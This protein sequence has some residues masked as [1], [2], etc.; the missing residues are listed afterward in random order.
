MAKVEITLN[1]L[2]NLHS[3]VIYNPDEFKN[4]SSV[5]ID[6]R[7]VVKGSIF[8]AIEG[9]KFDGHDFVND[10]EANDASALIINEKKLSKFDSVD[11]TIITVPDTTE[12]YGELAS[13][14][15]KKLSA[16]VISISGSNGKTTTKDILAVILSEKFNVVKTIANNNNHIGVPLTIFLADQKCEILILEHGTNHFGEIAYTAKIAIPDYVLLTNIGDSHL[17]FLIDRKGVYKEKSA[18]FNQH[19]NLLFVNND[20]KILSRKSAGIKNKIS[21]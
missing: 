8:F 2:F 20:D 5:V 12:A 17:E 4:S 11:A 1:D 18:L 7:E 21:F 10:A 16:K 14:W 9:E 3:A 13:M 6:S 15:R 19:K